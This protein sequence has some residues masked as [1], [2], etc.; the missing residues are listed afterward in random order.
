[1]STCSTCKH[2]GC[3]EDGGH[4]YGGRCKL[5]LPG[6]LASVYHVHHPARHVRQN[7]GCVA[8]ETTNE[9]TQQEISMVKIKVNGEIRHHI[10]E[11][12]SYAD[13]VKHAGY[14]PER[15]LGVVYG[16][17]RTGD[18]RRSGIMHKGCQPVRVEEGMFFTVA[19]TGSA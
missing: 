12:I 13:V 2:F 14:D 5:P 3:G 15:V 19:D 10:G 4:V 17:P 1:M 9:A 16:G 11:S 6:P 7:Y 18:A 8:W